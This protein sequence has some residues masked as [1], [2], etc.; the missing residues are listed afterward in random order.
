MDVQAIPLHALSMV[1]KALAY[2]YEYYYG[3]QTSRQVQPQYPESYTAPFPAFPLMPPM[4]MPFT[5]YWYWMP[6]M[7][8]AYPWM[9]TPYWIMPWMLYPWYLWMP[10]MIW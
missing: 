6:P 5:T 9:F 7:L 2:P 10:W 8:Y 3:R 4:V 1:V